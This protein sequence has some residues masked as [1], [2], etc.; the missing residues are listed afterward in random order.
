M[1]QEQKPPTTTMGAASEQAL[2]GWNR[3]TGQY[4]L[5][6]SPFFQ[7]MSQ[8]QG[9]MGSAQANMDKLYAWIQGAGPGGM[10]DTAG[11]FAQNQMTNAMQPMMQAAMQQGLEGSRQASGQMEQVGGGYS[12][13]AESARA[14]AFAT[15]FA[16]TAGQLG[17]LQAQLA[18]SALGTFGQGA[19]TLAQMYGQQMQTGL[20][21]YGAGMQGYTGLLGG[22]VTVVPPP[23]DTGLLS[24]L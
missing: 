6:N 4:D 3:A 22:E 2:G 10:G 12:G 24:W 9:M 8:G 18:G 20:G 5:A 17:Q 23:P 15:P 13:A 16:Q 7:G 21:Q 11:K 19:G 1:S 14:R